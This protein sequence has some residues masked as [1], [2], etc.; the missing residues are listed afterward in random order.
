[1]CCP[2][3]FIYSDCFLIHSQYIRQCVIFPFQQKIQYSAIP[4][5]KLRIDS[6]L[7]QKADLTFRP[8]RCACCSLQNHQI[9]AY[10]VTQTPT[11]PSPILFKFFQRSGNIL[12]KPFPPL[13][14]RHHTG[15]PHIAI[16]APPAFR[17]FPLR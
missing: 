17:I 3:I 4:I 5:H 13:T 1:M 14:I 7:R 11:V 9:A 12:F 2:S 6:F 8:K 10:T 15:I 16:S